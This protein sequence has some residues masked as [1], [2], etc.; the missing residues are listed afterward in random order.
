MCTYIKVIP[1]AVL[2]LLLSETDEIKAVKL[3]TENSGF[4]NIIKLPL[5]KDFMT[6]ILIEKEFMEC[7]VLIPND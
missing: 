7:P 3:S 5:L 1:R 2:L 4:Q 6:K